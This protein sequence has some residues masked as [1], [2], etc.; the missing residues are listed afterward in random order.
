MRKK[1]RRKTKQNKTNGTRR[2]R[3]TSSARYTAAAGRTKGRIMCTHIARKSSVQ[4]AGTSPNPIPPRQRIGFPSAAQKKLERDQLEMNGGNQAAMRK[5]KIKHQIAA[6][7]KFHESR[8]RG[9]RRSMQS[10]LPGT[11]D[12]EH[13]AFVDSKLCPK[14][15]AK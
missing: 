14:K 4:Y 8:H 6:K 2:R 7:C 12:A 5:K 15:S 10:A 13:L 11:F 1:R 9:K 3:I